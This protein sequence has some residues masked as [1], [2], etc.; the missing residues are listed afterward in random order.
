MS[1]DAD[2][3]LRRGV[4]A[5]LASF[6]LETTIRDLPPETVHATK[7]IIADTIA[8][9][10]GAWQTDAAQVVVRYRRD[11]GG[12]P[13]ASLPVDG[14]K[15]PLTSVSFVG[16]QLANILDADETLLNR[17]HYAS[18]IVMPALAAAEMHQR[19][20]AELIEAVAVGFDVAARVGFALRQYEILGEEVAWSP[21][22]GFD[23]AGLGTAAA[24]G[25]LVGLTQAELENAFGATFVT[26][27]V[28]FDNRRA[29]APFFSR[30]GVQP[31]WHK[32]A[33]YGA[34]AEAGVNGVL[35][36]QRGFLAD[37]HIL[38][39]DSEFQLAFGARTVDRPFLLDRLGVRWFIDET[40]IKPWP[41]CRYGHSALD[42][43]SDLVRGHG[44]SPEDIRA[45]EVEIPR[46]GPLEAIVTN[47]PPDDLFKIFM[48]LPYALAFVALG[49][50][51]G[52]QWW[53]EALMS[54]PRV[55]AIAARVSAAVRPDWALEV[56]SQ[57]EK[58]GVW[59]EMPVAVT[60]ST[61]QGTWR[62]ETRLAKGDPWDPR[63]RLTD[64]ELRSKVLEY[65][66]HHLGDHGASEL[67]AAAMGL[68][69]S[70][71]LDAMTDALIMKDRAEMRT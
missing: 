70:P 51:A 11:L 32:Y 5:T 14:S 28:N 57:V 59:R 44:L 40:S 41:F 58:D 15:L 12:R 65:A 53:D 42:L 46:F 3:T 13:D 48:N 29:N 61:P 52:P 47:S 43:F 7:R 64:D 10:I 45:I 24:V 69:T 63:F 37:R 27:P 31:N 26:L 49:I 56:V 71:S 22:F 20:G 39:D 6:A 55:S 18:C 36:A 62:T 2:Q 30:P 1:I 35:L 19:S 33:M 9:V 38:D 66:R 8:C 60:V 25:K 50:P 68:D 54:D 21:I 4:T 23:W 17:S 16:A 67:F 34:I